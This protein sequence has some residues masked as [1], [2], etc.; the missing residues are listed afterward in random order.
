MLSAKRSKTGA[1]EFVVFWD[2]F[3]GCRRGSQPIANSGQTPAAGMWKRWNR[4]GLI[5]LGTF[6]PSRGNNQGLQ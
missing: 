1:A 3:R 2:F 4:P 5:G 6:G